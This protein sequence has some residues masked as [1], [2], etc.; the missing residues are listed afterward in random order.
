MYPFTLN[1]TYLAENPDI[2][3]RD[4]VKASLFLHGKRKG[5]QD[6][7]E[8]KPYNPS[9]FRTSCAQNGYYFGYSETATDWYKSLI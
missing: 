2:S 6:A 5:I 3:R 8:D 7:L 9:Q 4:F 1:S